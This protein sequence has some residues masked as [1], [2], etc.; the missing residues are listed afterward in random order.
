NPNVTAVLQAPGFPP[1]QQAPSYV[2]P[3][4]LRG[5]RR[6]VEDQPLADRILG[7][8]TG[9]YVLIGIGLIALIVLGWAVWY[10]TSGQ[11]SSVPSSL[12]GMSVKD[13][14]AKLESDGYKVS[15]GAGQYSQS[16]AKGAVAATDPKPGTRISSGTLIT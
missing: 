7:M 10:Q 6:Q 5:Q 9:R 1:T 16:V 14:R 15:Q 8:F 13:A 2:P 12:I 11:Y 3:S 4:A